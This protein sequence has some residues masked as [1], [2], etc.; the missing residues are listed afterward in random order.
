MRSVDVVRQLI[1]S[2]LGGWEALSDAYAKSF[3]QFC[4]TLINNLE[5]SDSRSTAD[6]K[7]DAAAPTRRGAKSLPPEASPRVLAAYLEAMKS[8]ATMLTGEAARSVIARDR[9]LAALRSSG[10]SQ[11]E[12]ARQLDRKPT[13]ISRILK[14]P[15][16]SRLSTLQEI[17]AA[18]NVDITDLFEKQ[19]IAANRKKGRRTAKASPKKTGSRRQRATAREIVHN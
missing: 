7:Y 3:A 9:L 18:L 1:E 14:A 17:A 12:L 4:S 16:R 15:E 2:R 8:G 13:V 6:A 5:Q 10:M 19:V 11:A